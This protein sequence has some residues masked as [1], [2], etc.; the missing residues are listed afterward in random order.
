MSN[1]NKILYLIV[2]GVAIWSVNLFLAPM[3][4][5]DVKLLN[6]SKKELSIKQ[7]FNDNSPDN[8]FQSM[9]GFVLKTF[10]KNEVINLIEK[11]AN[12]SVV[13][14]SSLDIQAVDKT[15]SALI[16]SENALSGTDEA[17]NLENSEEAALSN[18]LKSVNLD[19]DIKGSKNAI[20]L[21]IDRLANSKQ[22]IDVQAI[23]IN[24]NN[25]DSDNV[26]E[27]SAQINALIY[28]VKL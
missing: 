10:D 17:S 21:F 9:N 25:S 15:T 13:V 23:N 27:L 20:D 22:Y 2:F 6:E 24:F 18:T 14:V 8:L 12:E 19:L 4:V 11:L 3:V 5:A 1:L 28:Y 7:S 16:V 26:T